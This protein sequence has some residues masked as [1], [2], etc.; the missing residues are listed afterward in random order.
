MKRTFITALLSLFLF[1]F[2]IQSAFAT[3][4]TME[5]SP[6]SGSF[7]KPFTVNLVIDGHGERFNAAETEVTIPSNLKIQNLTLG[8]CNFSFLKT[9]S[10]EQLS[11]KGILLSEYATK[12][13][14]YTI[15]FTPIAKG[16]TAVT[17]ANT[18]V[19]RFG[20][21]ADILA[22]TKNG[23][24]SLTGISQTTTT[25]TTTT[26]QTDENLYS[27]KLNIFTKKDEPANN[28]IV[29]LSPVEKKNEI[30]GTTDDKGSIHFPDVQSGVYS[31]I[32]QKDNQKVG[33]T[34]IN[35][36]GSQHVLTLSIDLEAQKNNPLL[37]KSTSSFNTLFTSPLFF[38]GILLIGI[39]LGII[40]P[41]FIKK[42]R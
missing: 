35:V 14:V 27:V 7:D 29:R 18:S 41:K 32:V 26:A 9:P 24:Y 28:A 22:S 34:I 4:T 38:G 25:N 39:G 12:C 33:E 13:T 30:T 37:K 42:I 20:D 6:S 3:N 8:D 36:S 17:L 40:L 1:S 21:A 19:K 16:N 10:K 31:V 23:T 5:L 11:F 15:T 2:Q